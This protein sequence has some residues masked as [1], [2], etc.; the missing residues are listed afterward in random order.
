MSVSGSAKSKNYVQNASGIWTPVG[1]ATGNSKMPVQV[2]DS[3]GVGQSI[4]PAGF[5]RTSDEPHQLFYDPFDVALDLVNDWAAT[6]SSGAVAADAAGVMTMGTGTTTSGWSKLASIPTFKPTVPSWLG[7]SSLIIIPDLA[8]PIANAY[9]YWGEGT[10]PASPTAAAPVTDGIGFELSTSGKMYAVVYSGGVR[11]QIADLSAATGTGT[12]P[13]DANGHR[14][15]IYV[16]TDRVYFYID[17]LASPVATANFAYPQM[18]TQSA[19]FLAAQ[20]AGTPPVSNAQIQCVGTAVWDTGKNS[21]QISDGAKPWRK[22]T[23][24]ANGALK[25]KDDYAGGEVLAD[26]TGAAGVL[27]FNF[28]SPVNLVVIFAN[29][30]ATDIARIDPFGGTP[31]AILG[32]P[33]GDEAAS[34]LPITTSSVK[35]YA[36]TGMV[37]SVSGFRRA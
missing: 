32:I 9:R 12:Q 13:T 20:T 30:A 2:Y 10:T 14:Y 19:L 23:V 24:D 11:N 25:A 28:A 22:V 18:Q 4:F 35:V 36:P 27:T 5:L 15:I 16:R 29:G 34:Y 31:T 37:I 3:S 26:Q 1:Y 33:V 21:T 7:F 17:S 8:A 6:T